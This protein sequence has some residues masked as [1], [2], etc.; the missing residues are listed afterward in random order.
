MNFK[1]GKW[2][3]QWLLFFPCVIGV[4]SLIRIIFIWFLENIVRPYIMIDSVGFNYYWFATGASFLRESFATLGS[5]AIGLLIV[6]KGKKIAFYLIC[7][8]SIIFIVVITIIYPIK[9]SEIGFWKSLGELGILMGQFTGVFFSLG[10]YKKEYFY[11][12]GSI[13]RF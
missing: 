3:I 13:H 8:L 11:E 5:L 6:E 2:A 7:A 1:K 10:C 4:N 12:Y 9:F